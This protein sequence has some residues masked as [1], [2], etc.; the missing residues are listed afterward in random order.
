[1]INQWQPSLLP[2]PLFQRLHLGPSQ[3][4]KLKFQS[5]LSI[6]HHCKVA[7]NALE[8]TNN[9]SFPLIASG[10]TLKTLTQFSR[11]LLG[12]KKSRLHGVC[13]EDLASVGVQ[14]SADL[15]ISVWPAFRATMLE[16]HLLDVRH[17]STPIRQVA[18]SR[19][20][21]FQSPADDAFTASGA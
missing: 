9:G 5:N 19:H 11:P 12:Q 16:R 2:L 7:L 15:I 21:I 1:M 17:P 14:D 10:T 20:P 4:L 13:V 8:N 18:A 6:C 3:G